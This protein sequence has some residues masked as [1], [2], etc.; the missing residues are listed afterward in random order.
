MS[1]PADKTWLSLGI[2]RKPS[3]LGAAELVV[4]R[5]SGT[6][7]TIPLMPSDLRSLAMDA[8]KAMEPSP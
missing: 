4:A 8:L 2:R 1:T 3:E 5:P 7:V 6:I